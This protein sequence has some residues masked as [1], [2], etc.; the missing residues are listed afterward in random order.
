MN[1]H[2]LKLIYPI[3]NI[4][5]SYGLRVK[6]LY[7]HLCNMYRWF[8][9]EISTSDCIFY[10]GR[11]FF[12]IKIHSNNINHQDVYTLYVWAGLHVC[13]GV[14]VEARVYRQCKILLFWFIVYWICTCSLTLKL[15]YHVAWLNSSFNFIKFICLFIYLQISFSLILIF[16]GLEENVWAGCCQC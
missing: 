15:Y 6:S 8:C 4:N 2:N 12:L 3:L 16:T 14:C 7:Q 10:T 9:S 1:S 5:T 13:V 11:C